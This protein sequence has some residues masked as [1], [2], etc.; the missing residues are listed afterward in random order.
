MSVALC[1][2][3][4]IHNSR[5]AGPFGKA[6][7]REVDGENAERNL[8]NENGQRNYRNSP[9]VKKGPNI[10]AFAGQFR[11]GAQLSEFIRIPG[12]PPNG[13]QTNPS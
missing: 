11:T 2:V 13:S 1:I 10:A 4:P 3:H 8:S 5:P 6:A 7:M 9:N 12:P